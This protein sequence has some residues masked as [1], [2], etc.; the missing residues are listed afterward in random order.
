[1]FA[2]VI[3]ATLLGFLFFS[4][5]SLLGHVLLRNWHESATAD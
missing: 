2:E 4:V 3:C 1:L 5:V